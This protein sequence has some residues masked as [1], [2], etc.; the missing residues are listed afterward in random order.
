MTFNIF[1]RQG[2]FL[3][4]IQAVNAKTA[5]EK[6]RDQMQEPTAYRAEERLP[7]NFPRSGA[8]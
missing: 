6:F 2:K 4:T 5:V 7:D 1:D 3:G 8:V